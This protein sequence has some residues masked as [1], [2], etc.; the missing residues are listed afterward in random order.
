MV[1]VRL[2]WYECELA[3]SVGCKR[4]LKAL[5]QGNPDK[6]GFEGLGWDNH[7]EG[8]AAE[9]AVA[10]A[11]GLYWGAHVNIFGDADLGTRVQVRLRTQHHYDLIVR[12][13]DADDHAFV[14]VTGRLPDYTIHGWIWG[15]AAKHPEWL[16]TYGN[17][18]AAYFVPKQALTHIIA[19]RREVHREVTEAILGQDFEPDVLGRPI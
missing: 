4:Q 17:R 9:M 16:K 7:V 11:R 15:N 2:S 5:E 19:E 12:P 3:A 14:L 13:N 6:H 8:A 18:P 10:K 1:D